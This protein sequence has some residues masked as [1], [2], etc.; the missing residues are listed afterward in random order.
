MQNSYCGRR[1]VGSV[2]MQAVE[3]YQHS[4]YYITCKID[5]IYFAFCVLWPSRLNEKQAADH[6][7]VFYSQNFNNSYIKV[8]SL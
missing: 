7:L 4:I 2:N 3:I 6:T 8:T 5:W 1:N